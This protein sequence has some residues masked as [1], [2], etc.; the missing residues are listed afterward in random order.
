[1][2]TCI[3]FYCLQMD[4]PDVYKQAANELWLYEKQK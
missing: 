1:M 3:I 4:R 2:W